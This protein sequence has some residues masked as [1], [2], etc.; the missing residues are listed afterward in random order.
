[1]QLNTSISNRELPVNRRF[2]SI[3]ALLVCRNLSP[4]YFFICNPTIKTLPLQDAQLDFC[5]VQPRAVLRCW[6]KFQLLGNTPSLSGFKRF[7]QRGHLVRIEIIQDNADHLGLWVSDIDQPFHLM[8]KIHF[9]PSL[10]DGNVPPASL[11]LTDHKQVA[12]AVALVLIVIALNSASFGWQT[13]ARL[14]DQL[15]AGLIKVYFRALFIKGLGV[16][17]QH[18]F[19]ASDELRIYFPDTPLLFEPGLELVF[20]SV[21]RTSSY[22]QES[23]SLSCTTRSASNC[24]VHCLRPSGALLQASAIKRAC[25]F[26]S[27]FGF[28]PGRGRSLMASNPA[29]TNRLRRRSTVATPTL[30][31]VTISSSVEPASALSR[32]RARVSL[33]VDVLPRWIRC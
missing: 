9:S 19:H 17:L 28:L 26:G 15:L 4:Q 18:I 27:S 8:S 16:Q 7:I 13:S 6:M 20:F 5:H 32:I 30:R 33:R 12:R 23:A 14:Y 11:R 2:I 24:K 25:A 22:E 21:R 3:A 1:M 29:S 31:A 10:C